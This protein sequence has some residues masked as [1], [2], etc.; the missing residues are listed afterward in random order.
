MS[1]RSHKRW[2]EIRWP[3]IGST[4][5]L[6]GRT[7]AGDTYVQ[8]Q[9]FVPSPPPFPSARSSASFSS[10]SQPADVSWEICGVTGY[11]V[12]SVNLSVAAGECTASGRVSD[13]SVTAID[14]PGRGD[15]VTCEMPSDDQATPCVE[16][17]DLV[18][19]GRKNNPDIVLPSSC[20]GRKIRFCVLFADFLLFPKWVSRLVYVFVLSLSIELVNCSSSNRLSD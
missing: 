14:A 3:E 6:V 17:S 18:S 9:T 2:S 4:T 13:H 1:I 16:Y 19:Y 5:V 12:S 20:V 10:S 8:T 7:V 15:H 11:G